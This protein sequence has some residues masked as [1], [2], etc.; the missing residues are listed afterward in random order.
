MIYLLLAIFAT[1]VINNLTAVISNHYIS[2]GVGV[3]GIIACLW[4]LSR[5]NE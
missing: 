3:A 2:L 1:V 5:L 4:G